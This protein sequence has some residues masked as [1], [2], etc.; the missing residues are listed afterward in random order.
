MEEILKVNINRMKLGTL[1][2]FFKVNGRFHNNEKDVYFFRY[3][4]YD[5]KENYLNNIKK[6]DLDMNERI[7]SRNCGYNRIKSFD[8]SIPSEDTVYYNHVYEEFQLNG[9]V[10]CRF[11]FNDTLLQGT[12]AHNISKI[13]MLY[14]NTSSILSESMVKNFAIKIFYWIDNYFPHV[15]LPPFN[16]EVSPKFVFSGS[17]KMQ[18]YLF[19][20]LLSCMGCDVLYLNTYEDISL[21]KDLFKLS[22]VYIAF[23]HSKLE[24]PAYEKKE[25]HEKKETYEKKEAHKKKEPIGNKTNVKSPVPPVQNNPF[26]TAVSSASVKVDIRRPESYKR[27]SETKQLPSEPLPYTELANLAS[28]VVMIS[29][30]DGNHECFKTGSGVIVGT[31]GYILTNFHVANNAYYYSV[32]IEEEET[33]YE[34][35]EL[36]K[37]NAMYD[38]GLIRIQRRC[39]PIPVYNGKT[40][41]VR[42]QKVVAIGSPLGLFNSV[43]DGI[44]SGFRQ[45]DET[46]MIQFTAPISHGSSGGALLNLYGELI[47]LITAHFGDGQNLNLAVD[48]KIL[49][50]FITGFI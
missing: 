39:K 33:V 44:I 3:I 17:I 36:I 23:N 5:N 13:I 22:Q 18:E 38:L 15:F 25:A 10:K 20:Y 2:S 31:E 8:K 28:S 1:D 12:L 16:L 45:I 42:G 27:K 29:A 37:Y 34:T 40:P 35:N 32:K 19:L 46:S 50:P 41:L 21:N 11:Q 4:G 48:Y 6:Y 43:S 47:G 7:H 14:R 26:P 24:L 30:F 9:L 49:Q